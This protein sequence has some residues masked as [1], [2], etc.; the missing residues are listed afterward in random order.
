MNVSINRQSQRAHIA[1][2][3]TDYVERHS[4][5]K[6]EKARSLARAEGYK[7]KRDTSPSLS[8]ML[9]GPA[10]RRPGFLARFFSL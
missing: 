10:T 5:R 7:F 4:E 3:W 8:T 6:A 9:A 1:Q 2:E